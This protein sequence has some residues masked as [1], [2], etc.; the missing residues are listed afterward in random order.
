MTEIGDRQ[1]PRPRSDHVNRGL[2]RRADVVAAAVEV[3][4]E[5]GYDG[6]SVREIA[7]RAGMFKGNLT[8]YFAV[9]DDLLFEVVATLHDRFLQLAEGWSASPE[10]DQAP[11]ALLR[12]AFRQHV[13]LVCTHSNAARVSYEAFRHLNTGRRAVIVDK[14]DRY[15]AELQRII[16]TCRPGR[17]SAS[18]HA[19]RTRTVLG[20]LNWPYQWYAP[21]G[22]LEPDA[23]A[24]LVA[25]MAIRALGIRTDG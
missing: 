22:G 4:A 12:H 10:G 3:F 25:D 20:M 24:D 19:A 15:E 16:K 17:G 13:R 18:T 21:H 5:R 8:Y 7:E 1:S 11:C 2:S 23:L 6:A 9:K 14:R